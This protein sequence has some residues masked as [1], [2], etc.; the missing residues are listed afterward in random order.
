MTSE[1]I[2]SVENARVV[3]QTFF[4]S[5]KT[6]RERN[7]LGQFA[8]PPNL[9]LEIAR[10]ISNGWGTQSNVLNFF[11]PAFGTGAFYS[12]LLQSLPDNLWGR[13]SAI[14]I[15][16][17]LMEISQR[18]WQ[19]YPIKI[20]N[21]DFTKVEPPSMELDR[22]NLILT[23]PPYVR[24]HHIPQVDKLRLKKRILD[25]LGITVSGLS[26][27]YVYFMLIADK[28]L[29]QNG[30]SVWLI[31]SEFMDVKYGS[32]LREYLTHRV[33]LE[34]IH[35]F[36]PAEVQFS[37]AMVSSAVVIFRK[38]VPRNL[39]C[40]TLTFGGSLCSPKQTEILSIKLLGEMEKW[41]GTIFKSEK[42]SN[43]NQTYRRVSKEHILSEFF[44]I[45]RGI[46]TGDNNFFIMTL[47]EARKKNIPSAYIKPIFPNPRHITNEVIEPDLDGFPLS[48]SK[49]VV[50]DCDLPESE[51]QEKY[52]D[53]WEYLKSGKDKGIDKRY[54][55]SKRKP[56]YRQ[57]QR[58]P[59]PFL[60]TYM[61]RSTVKNS[62]KPFRFIWNR[63]L[64]TAHNVYL[65]LYPKPPLDF[66]LQTK[67]DSGT[68][69]REILRTLQQISANVM[70]DA[71]RVYGGSLHKLEPSELGRVPILNLV[72]LLKDH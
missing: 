28:W 13:A 12:A 49:L 70:T 48:T 69:Y 8:T 38:E 46:A 3:A 50:I 52:P 55:P 45:K 11:E 35:R 67:S 47:E 56:W 25:E 18:I 53:F 72:D 40:A 37:D 1:M 54:L 61:G 2:S 41:N 65:L 4:D 6:A 71:G 9:A 7:E 24:H 14:E 44:Q 31:P 5:T 29:A 51:L 32:V 59:A 20:I 39:H 64:A 58:P 43:H 60:C 16:T 62:G 23:N 27:L 66:L 33:T 22:Y 30:L 63:S 57:E 15:D 10:H 19:N 21:G 26:G 17:E 36:D 34:R 68:S 42:L